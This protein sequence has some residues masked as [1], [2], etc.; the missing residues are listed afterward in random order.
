MNHTDEARQQA[1]Q[2]VKYL[3][4]NGCSCSEATV[5]AV[6]EYLWGD[7]DDSMCRASTA[8]SGGVGGTHAEICGAA[9]GAAMIIGALY[10]RATS[11]EDSTR[12]R[13]VMVRYRERFLE[14]FKTTNCQELR[15]GGYGSEQTPCWMLVQEAV[16][17]LLLL[18]AEEQANE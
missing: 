9:S 5:Q 4:Q 6:G 18:L 10:G 3:M 14:R 7:V 13:Q 12:C 15:D 16:D 8:F 1:V 2:R 11:A 17:D